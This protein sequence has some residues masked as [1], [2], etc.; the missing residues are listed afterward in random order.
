M[1]IL[2]INDEQTIDL[3]YRV[4]IDQQIWLELDD[5]V[6]SF[7]YDHSVYKSISTMMMTLYP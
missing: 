2:M 3:L 1:K 7:D 6:Q 4:N 5:Q